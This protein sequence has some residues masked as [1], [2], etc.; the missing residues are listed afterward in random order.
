MI[1]KKR[2]AAETKSQFIQTSGVH[3]EQSTSHTRGNSPTGILVG[4]DSDFLGEREFT[5]KGL[6]YNG[7]TALPL[8]FGIFY[9]IPVSCILF[10][11]SLT[12]SDKGRGGLS[13]R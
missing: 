8:E 2:V 9:Y 4:V 5:L 12:V 11:D 6:I 10:S 1:K 3:R 13:F 7:L